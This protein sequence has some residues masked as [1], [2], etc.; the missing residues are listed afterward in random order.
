MYR[1]L[2]F[3]EVEVAYLLITR[4]SI[5]GASGEL[6]RSVRG[7]GFS[8]GGYLGA[9]VGMFMFQLGKDFLFLVRSKLPELLPEKS[10]SHTWIVPL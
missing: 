7:R 9:K 3:L 5:V 10:R 2:K 4:T 1:F 8:D 6:G